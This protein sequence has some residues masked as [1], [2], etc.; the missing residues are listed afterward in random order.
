[1]NVLTSIKILGIGLLLLGTTTYGQQKPSGK[2]PEKAK[3]TQP[4]ELLKDSKVVKLD[5]IAK[6][7]VVA[8]SLAAIQP[9]KLK[10]FKKSAHA[11]YYHQKFNGKRTS[12]G[13][14]FD[15]NKY[16]AA[17]RKFPF[18]TKLKIT[19]EVNHKSV[20]VEVI[21]RGPFS[22]GREIDLTKKAFMEIVDNKNSGKVM[23]TIEEIIPV[24]V[25]APKP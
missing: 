21:D 10:P 4:K 9:L 20:I 12:S 17:H 23:V 19:N 18:G 2:L 15:N 7:K 8:D 6:T 5:S 16:T 1:M 24:V 25:P 14:R 3:I 13:V 22:K 11:S